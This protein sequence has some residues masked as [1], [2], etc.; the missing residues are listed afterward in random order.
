MMHGVIGD[1]AEVD[2]IGVFGDE[3]RSLCLPVE[4][5]ERFDRFGFGV[6]DE[7]FAAPLQDQPGVFGI[8][9]NET[10]GADVD[11]LGAVDPHIEVVFGA[12]GAGVGVE[13]EAAPVRGY[14]VA[15]VRI[16]FASFW[17]AKGNLSAARADRVAFGVHVELAEV[18]G[19][20]LVVVRPFGGRS[21]MAGKQF[22]NFGLEDDHAA[23]TGQRDP[24]S[25]GAYP[26]GGG[27]GGVGTTGG[28][29]DQFDVGRP[30]GYRKT[31][32]AFAED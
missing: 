14:G 21:G 24:L 10:V 11:G 31:P 17:G 18:S 22:A 4:L 29:D 3:K 1:F 7:V 9:A 20:V 6:V 23:V 16:S 15:G 28:T 12:A 13:E 2:D 25:A 26:G 27:D 30:G 8:R 19:G 5:G 32:L